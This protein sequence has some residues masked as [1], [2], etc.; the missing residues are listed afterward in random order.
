LSCK[1]TLQQRLAGIDINTQAERHSYVY[2]YKFS[3]IPPQIITQ[4]KNSKHSNN[5]YQ[6]KKP[7]GSINYSHWG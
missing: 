6:Y 4:H 7:G 1:Q 5:S 3:R 2:N